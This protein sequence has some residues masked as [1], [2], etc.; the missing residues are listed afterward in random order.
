MKNTSIDLPTTQKVKLVCKAPDALIGAFIASRK[1]LPNVGKYESEFEAWNLF[2]LAIRNL[3][4][5]IHL[6]QQDLVLL[7]PA[8]AAARSYRAHGLRKAACKALAHAGC[9]GP[10]IMSVSGHS[11]LAQVQVYIDDF[12]REQMA[13]AAIKKLKAKRRTGSD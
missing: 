3:E 2:N 13:D 7:P 6:A 9:T 10:E 12:E 1:T 5:V 8:L 4:G 11:S